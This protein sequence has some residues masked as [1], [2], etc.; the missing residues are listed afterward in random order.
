MAYYVPDNAR[1]RVSLFSYYGGQIGINSF[2]TRV[3]GSVTGGVTLEEIADEI[4]SGFAT[5]MVDLLNSQ[6]Q[7]LGVKAAVEGVTPQ[8]LPGTI[9]D[10]LSGTA[11][12]DV[13]PSQSAGILTLK[14]DWAGPSG[15]GR[16]Y[17]PFPAAASVQVNNLAT[18]TYLTNMATLATLIVGPISVTG[19]TGSATVTAGLWHQPTASFREFTGYTPQPRFGTQMRRGQYG[20]ANPPVVS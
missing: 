9:Q 12:L 16:L 15:R 19:A 3:S 5:T 17:I 14:T 6:A 8:P 7:F 13:V 4:D 11:G 18:P 10:P 1:V 20:R 2:L